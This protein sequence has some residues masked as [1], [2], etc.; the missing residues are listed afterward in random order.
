MNATRSAIVLM[1]LALSVSA[2]AQSS[3][4]RDSAAVLTPIAVAADRN[5]ILDAV[6]FTLRREHG[7]GRYITS[8][9]IARKSSFR[10]TDLLR[11]IPGLRVGVTKYGDDVVFS[12][13]SGGS[14]LSS[15]HACVQYMVD[16]IPFEGSPGIAQGMKLTPEMERT[17]YEMAQK[18]AQDLNVLLQKDDLLGIEVYQG[19]ET[20]PKFNRGGGNCATIVIWTKN[21][22][23]K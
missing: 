9:E 2:A 14:L 22:A 8:E 20:P 11:I 12:P 6:G 18:A 7:V 4:R 19:S 10:F 15:S 16:G 3:P 21:G 1:S 23:A 17:L 13:R 5:P